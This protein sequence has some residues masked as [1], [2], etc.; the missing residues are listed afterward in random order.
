MADYDKLQEGVNKKLT[1]N[2]VDKVKSVGRIYKESLDKIRAEMVILYE[3]Y[4]VDGKLTMGKMT[5]FKR[6]KSLEKNIVGILN[7]MYPLIRTSIK[8]G[9]N[10][11]TQEAFW[12]EAWAVD[13]GWGVRL[14]WGVVPEH[15]MKAANL[16][17][18]TANA[19]KDLGTVGRISIRNT[20]MAGIAEGSGIQEMARTIK[21]SVQV[22]YNRAA[23]IIRTEF[24]R[25]QELGKYG[26][27][28]KAQGFGLE[29]RLKLLAVL[30]DR[31]RSQS[32]RMDNQ[33]S[34]PEGKFKYPDGG[35]YI[36]GN[37]GYAK[38][39][40]NDRETTIQI[41]DNEDPLLRRTKRDGVIPFQSFE[42]W[43]KDRGITRNI[44][45]QKLF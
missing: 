26:E 31:T 40:I 14:N 36:A 7:K 16:N 45:G 25:V 20:I 17:P 30:D 2:T 33:L 11:Q 42:T 5:Q 3:K 34:N 21:K 35:Y 9:I 27:F 29:P 18:L 24:H 15:I 19:L 38:W 6:L 28:E 4:S 44:Y 37:S 8:S 1:K 41:I 22:N 32:A 12:G 39:D 13:N 43:A 23:K 10:I